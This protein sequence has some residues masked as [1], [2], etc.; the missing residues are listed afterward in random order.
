MEKVATL[1]GYSY[2]QQETKKG[3]CYNVVPVNEPAPTGGYY[4]KE[5]I[6]RIKHV[7][8]M[9]EKIP[10]K[11]IELTPGEKKLLAKVKRELLTDQYA[12]FSSYGRCQTKLYNV[13]KKYKVDTQVIFNLIP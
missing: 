5:Y 10:E 3:M 2:Y 12:T 4:A 7:P 9:F 6:L 13:A 11:K 8:D 1:N